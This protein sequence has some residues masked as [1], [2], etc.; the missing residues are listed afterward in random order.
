MST[1]YSTTKYSFFSKLKTIIIPDQQHFT[2]RL[3]LFGSE[4]LDNC[5]NTC[6]FQYVH[7]YLKKMDNLGT[8]AEIYNNEF[9]YF[10]II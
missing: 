8:C 5:N 4:L 9:V 2:T 3:L 7:E 6:I 10:I 1:V